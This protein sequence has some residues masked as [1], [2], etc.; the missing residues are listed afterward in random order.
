MYRQV[1]Q[2][3]TAPENLELPFNGQLSPENPWVVMVS[4]IPWPKYEDVYAS[5]LSEERGAPA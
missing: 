1:G 2:G 5:L 3:D 4:L